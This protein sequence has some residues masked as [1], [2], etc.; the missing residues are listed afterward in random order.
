MK[1]EA[2]KKLDMILGKM[3]YMKE[4]DKEMKEDIHTI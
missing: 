2:M 1:M 4:I 3:L